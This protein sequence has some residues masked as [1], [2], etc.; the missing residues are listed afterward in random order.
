LGDEQGRRRCVEEQRDVGSPSM[1]DPDPRCGPSGDASPDSESA[2]PDRERPPPGVRSLIPARDEEVDPAADQPGREAPQRDLVD[3]LPVAAYSCPATPSDRDRR[4]NADEVAQAVDVDEERADPEAVVAW[5]R[6][7]AERVR[8]R[9]FAPPPAPRPRRMVP[10][11]RRVVLGR[12]KRFAQASS[13]RPRSCGLFST[14]GSATWPR[15]GCGSHLSYAWRLG[16]G[17]RWR[18]WRSIDRPASTP[19]ARR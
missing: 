11:T 17:L 5:T 7:G 8:R 9:I 15:L 14:S 19:L 16:S 10:G 2:L 13:G 18:F 12:P 4:E 3:E 1:Q 6:N